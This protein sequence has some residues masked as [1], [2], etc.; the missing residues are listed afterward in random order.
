[1]LGLI[2][3]I[4]SYVGFWAAFT[5]FVPFSDGLFAPKTVDS[6]LPT[7]VPTALAIDLGVVL[8]FGLQHSLM[9]RA[10]FKR[11][12]TRVVPEH[13]ERATYVLASS[14]VLVV[15]MWQWRP[16]PTVLWNV[17]GTALSASL[18]TVNVLGWL[19]VPAS[20][21]MIDHFDLFGL[22]RAFHGFRKASYERKGFVA[23]LFYKYVRHPMMTSLLVGLWATPHMTVGHLLLS[24]GMSAYI[25]VGVHF[26][27]RSLREELG[28]AY[29]RYQASTPKF[30]PV[31]APKTT[32]TDG[33]SGA[34]TSGRVA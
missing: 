26:E 3:S 16:L 1:M 17:H 15:L 12:L 4:A 2:Y 24:V 25:V 22:K 29:E 5:Y 6:G 8:L 7:D 9:A 34:P 19:G 33:T 28:V 20:S 31:G 21:F 30:L 23:P 14:V 11:A 18:W 13:L 27:E 32:W 10:S